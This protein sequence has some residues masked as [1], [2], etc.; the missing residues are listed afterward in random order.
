MD[1]Q[2]VGIL[3]HHYNSE[4]H[5]FNRLTNQIE[6]EVKKYVPSGDFVW[7]RLCLCT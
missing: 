6:L 3:P 5:E 7:K 4:D 1:L 2:N